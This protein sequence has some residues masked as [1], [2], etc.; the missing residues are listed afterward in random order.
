MSQTTP[1]I[2]I[3]YLTDWK[4]L[5]GAILQARAH[6]WCNLASLVA[7]ACDKPASMGELVELCMV[8]ETM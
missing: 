7:V 4:L 3:A 8:L 1:K 6:N 5:D 2:I